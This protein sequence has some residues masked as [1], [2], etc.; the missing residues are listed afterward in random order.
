MT[1]VRSNLKNGYESYNC[2]QFEAKDMYNEDTHE[3]IY[4]CIEIK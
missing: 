3:Q 1:E 4:K 2:E